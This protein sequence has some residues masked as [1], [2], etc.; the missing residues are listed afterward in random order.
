MQAVEQNFP[1]AEIHPIDIAATLAMRRDWEFDRMG[2]DELAMAVE[3]SWRTYAVTL[4]W[5]PG[6][7][8]LRLLVSF[9][10]APPKRRRAA[11]N[12]VI[13]RANEACWSGAF[14]LWPEE[15]LMVWRYG[16]TLAGGA[17]PTPEQI[18]AM[19][20]AALGACE[21]FYPAFQLVAWGGEKP[22]AAMAVAMGEAVGRA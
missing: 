18:E 3:G 6:E 4:A 11:L 9:E 20:A 13:N 2:E 14:A 8:S 5:R 22:E 21:R 12:D 17:L 15:E 1:T 10:M 7:E 16:L 19:L